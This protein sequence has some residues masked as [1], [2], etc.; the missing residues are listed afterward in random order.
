QDVSQERSSVFGVQGAEKALVRS[1]SHN[2]R[3]VS[4]ALLVHRKTHDSA[5][6]HAAGPT[7][8]RETQCSLRL[9]RFTCS[10]I[11]VTRRPSP[12]TWTSLIRVFSGR[13]FTGSVNENACW[14]RA[15]GSVVPP[16]STVC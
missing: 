9:S 2:H 11:V 13:P 5:M 10:P 8:R 1:R 14:T 15:T 4:P 12:P 7:G 3:H 6:I 16:A